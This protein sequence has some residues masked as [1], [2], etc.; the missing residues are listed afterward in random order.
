MRYRMKK[1][2]VCVSAV[3][4][5]KASNSAIDLLTLGICLQ[6][7]KMT[8]SLTIICN[9]SLQPALDV[10]NTLYNAM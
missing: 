1:K 3:D 10:S 6:T 9:Q 2:C 7:I 5:D 4:I 8:L